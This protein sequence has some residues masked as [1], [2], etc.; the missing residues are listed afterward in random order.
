MTVK[1]NRW[2]MLAA[3]VCINFILGGVY[4]FSFFK[5]PL[6]EAYHWDPALLALA[7]SINMGII[8]IPMILGGKMIDN[9]KGKQAIVIGCLLFSLGFILSGFVKTLPMLLLTYGLIAGFGSGLAFTGNLN[10]ILKFF[11]DKRGLASGVVLSGVGIGTLLCTQLAEFFLNKTNDISKSL[12]YLGI[13]YLV[14]VF[15]VQFFIQSAPAKDSGQ[16]AD[17]PMDKDYKEMLKDSRFWVLFLI[18][19]LGV[20]SG[21]VISSSSAQIGMGQFGLTSGAL[22]VSL[23]S[24]F[25]SAGRLF[26]GGVS[27][28]LGS[29]RA[30]TLVYGVLGICMVLL[31]VFS[32]NTTVFYISALGIG[33]AYA[34]VL[35]IFPGLTS[36]N[37][38]M[39]NQGMNYGFMYFGFAVGAIVA[40]YVTAAVAKA[41]GSYHMAFIL[42]IILLVVGVVLIRMMEAAFKKMT[43][44]AA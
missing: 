18:L 39:K 9:G 35:T 1:V 40:P 41:T 8:P 27:D 34:G 31:L 19:A 11:P 10:N 22:I 2:G 20:F 5:N 17:S 36:Q 38:G 42:S 30:L 7:F 43:K 16:I 21:M 12:L 14:V 26:W 32:G 25:N 44:K 37:F 28:K 6:M 29:Y 33:F 13:V 15:V 24:I 3:H 4:A 23:V